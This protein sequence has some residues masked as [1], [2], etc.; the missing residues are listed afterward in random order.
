MKPFSPSNAGAIADTPSRWIDMSAIMSVKDLQW[1]AKSIVHGFNKGIHRSLQHGFSVE[2]SE[3]RPFSEGDDPRAVDWKLFARTDRLY[4]KRFEDETNRRCFVVIDQSRSMKFSSIDYSKSDYANTLAATLAYYWLQQRDAVGAISFSARIGDIVPAQYRPGQLKRI[5]SLVDQPPTG[6]ATHLQ[7][8]LQQI[9]NWNQRRSLV[10][11]ISDFLVP[12]STEVRESLARLA[13]RKH[14]VLLVQILDP[15]ETNWAGTVP[16]MVRDLESNAEIFVDPA[17]AAAAYA[18]RFQK[19]Q[20][21]WRSMAES[22]GI[23]WLSVQ[24]TH[25]LDGVL[26]RL[27]MTT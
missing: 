7:E 24:T 8:P 27:V 10:A 18:A 14:D 16:V 9:A 21:Q 3:Y 15:A 26:R 2:F 20:A 5:L 17:S 1:R 4:I 13:A 19:H 22:L 11:I 25:P 12:A 6:T 23:P